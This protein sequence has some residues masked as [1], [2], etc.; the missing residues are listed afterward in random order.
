VCARAL[1]HTHTRT[2]THNL[3]ART[4]LP[5][6]PP[7]GHEYST[8]KRARASTT[9]RAR[10]C[11]IAQTRAGASSLHDEMRK[12]PY[13]SALLYA[14]DAAVLTCERNGTKIPRNYST[15]KRA[16][17]FRKSRAHQPRLKRARVCMI[18]HARAGVRSPHI[19]LR[20]P[21][22]LSS[23]LSALCARCRRLNMCEE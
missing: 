7:G 6:P 18:A 4:L 13:F 9:T 17:A 15:L 3:Q 20:K 10:V 5:P 21:P 22:C 19:E 8:L 11:N 23:L 12:L 1:P 14:L 2:P 16:H